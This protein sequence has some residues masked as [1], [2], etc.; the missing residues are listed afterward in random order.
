M[1]IFAL[2]WVAF[3]LTGFGTLFLIGE[4]LVN[5]RGIFGILGIGFIVIYFSAYL[6]PGT[7]ILMLIIYFV[8]LLLIIIDG[9]FVNDGTL[10]TLGLVSMLTAV[11]LAADDFTTGLYAV[12][13]LL[14]GGAGSFLFLKVFKR[15]NMWGKLAL[16]D[17]L[18]T[19]A[20]YNSMNKDYQSLI[21]QEGITLN[22]LR[23]V[24]T[25]RINNKD[26]SAVSN[27]QWIPKNTPVRV[28]QVDG[29]KILVKEIVKDK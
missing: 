7:I 15:R 26:Y 12:I 1:E 18:T 2:S 27:A 28:I 17:R 9:K 19:D 24:G 25:I 3:L 20:G 11:A 6:E 29:T 21:G 22:V 23:P 13:G 16:T 14:L 8:G 10:A 5:M 4:V